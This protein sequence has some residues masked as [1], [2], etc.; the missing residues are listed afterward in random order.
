MTAP[1]KAT[2]RK[3]TAKLDDLQA[4]AVMG[5]QP[6]PIELRGGE[7]LVKPVLDWPANVLAKISGGDLDAW[8]AKC[9]T[10]ESAERWAEMEPTFRELNE[11]FLQ[12]GKATGQDLGELLASLRS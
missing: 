5:D 6:F 4:D 12:I 9:L 10:P 7:L 3:P 8:A 2:A 1:R 11:V